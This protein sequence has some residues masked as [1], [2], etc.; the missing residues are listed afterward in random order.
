M[1]GSSRSVLGTRNAAS[2]CLNW[3]QVFHGSARAHPCRFVQG[4]EWPS[5]TVAHSGH[6][7]DCVQCP[8]R[9]ARSTSWVAV[10]CTFDRPRVG[11][12]C[13]RSAQPA[14]RP[15]R[16]R[17]PLG[18]RH[19]VSPLREHCLHS[20]RKPLMDGSFLRPPFLAPAQDEGHP[21][22]RPR[23]GYPSTPRFT[24]AQR[25]PTRGRANRASWDFGVPTT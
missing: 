11:R 5:R 12:C 23:H 19:S 18:L 6:S 21:P 24:P 8:R 17:Q 15:V 25:V 14:A 10:P 9:P 13:P 1:E 20:L 4:K 3:M 22:L 16:E 7:G 2:P